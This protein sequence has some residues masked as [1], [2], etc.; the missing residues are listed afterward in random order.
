[1][2]VGEPCGKPVGATLQERE[3]V[4]AVHPQSHAFAVR[5]SRS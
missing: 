4:E 3:A 1:M 2:M 5:G